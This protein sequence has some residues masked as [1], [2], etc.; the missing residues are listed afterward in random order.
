MKKLNKITKKTLI[1]LTV[2]ILAVFAYSC[3]N[4]ST[5]VTTGNPQM[6]VSLKADDTSLDQDATLVLDSAKGLLETVKLEGSGSADIKAG[7]FVVYIVFNGTLNTIAVT[8]I[9]AGTYDKISFKFHKYNPNEPVLDADFGSGNTPGYSFII[10]GKYNGVPFIY[11]SPKTA[12]QQVSVNPNV[13]VVP[14]ISIMYNVTLVVNPKD[15]FLK[16]GLILDP[17]DPA[18]QNDIDNNIQASFKKSFKDD[19]KNGLPD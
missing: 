19:D 18:N 1:Y 11:R 13:I 12:V 9:N 16:D 10:A 8:N 7:P 14:Q 17:T 15:W 2:A 5:G 6:S 4:N 3:N